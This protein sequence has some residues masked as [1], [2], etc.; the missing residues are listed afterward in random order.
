MSSTTK[1]SC[2]M[3]PSL[4]L[5]K[6]SKPVSD[7]LKNTLGES[8]LCYMEL[9]DVAHTS[10]I[11][12]LV[13]EFQANL[14]YR[15]A[16]VNYTTPSK[17][18]ILPTEARSV[19]A[20]Q[21]KL[22]HKKFK[23]GE[24]LTPELLTKVLLDVE[25]NLGEVGA[26]VKKLATFSDDQSSNIQEAAEKLSTK[27]KSLDILMGDLTSVPEDVAAADL[28]SIIKG[29][30]ARLVE[31][32]VSAQSAPSSAEFA[33]MKSSLE[34]A[35]LSLSGL[36]T[37]TTTLSTKVNVDVGNDISNIMQSLT[38]VVNHLKPLIASSKQLQSDICKLQQQTFGCSFYCFC[39]FWLT[40]SCWH[41]ERPHVQCPGLTRS[42]GT[43]SFVRGGC[44]FFF[45]WATSFSFWQPHSGFR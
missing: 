8:V 39:L 19:S 11:L 28:A 1:N 34:T 12:A 38:M 25:N 14:G 15:E 22:P 7:H 30:H 23:S 37:T 10:G 3:E 41:V 33:K 31:V 45:N 18:T 9:F 13:E 42:V 29:L 26:D 20:Y 44:L 36:K 17:S 27:I 6:V 21:P 35:A 40:T 4:E 24:S 43:G 16:A 2:F 32:E 5:Q